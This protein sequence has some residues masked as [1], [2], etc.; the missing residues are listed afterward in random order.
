MF[1]TTSFVDDLTLMSND[2]KQ[3]Q[4]ALDVLAEFMHDTQQQVNEKK[5]KAFKLKR[6]LDVALHRR[7]A[8]ECF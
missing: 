6:R 4:R 3:L 5:T 7:S 2:R 1:K 8:G